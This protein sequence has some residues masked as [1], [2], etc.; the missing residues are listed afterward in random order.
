MTVA[1]TS[2]SVS[3]SDTS[4]YIADMAADNAADNANTKKVRKRARHGRS[5]AELEKASKTAQAYLTKYTPAYNSHHCSCPQCGSHLDVQIGNESVQVLHKIKTDVDSRLCLC[6][7]CHWDGII[8]HLISKS[9]AVTIKE[10]FQGSPAADATLVGM[11]RLHHVMD[12]INQNR[13]R[14]RISV[15]DRSPISKLNML[16]EGQPSIVEL[17]ITHLTMDT[18]NCQIILLTEP[19]IKPTNVTG[20]GR[21]QP[22]P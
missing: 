3:S 17:S 15:H 9:E 1:S 14:V 7:K 19:T 21:R 18:H 2:L 12:W 11:M 20:T 22:R 4:S 10:N 16:G 6:L 8:H 5:T 13:K